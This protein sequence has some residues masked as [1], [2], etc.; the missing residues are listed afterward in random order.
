M[1]LALGQA[2]TP[3]RLAAAGA[4]AAGLALLSAPRAALLAAAAV[5]A[6]G[7]A[8]NVRLAAIDAAGERLQPGERVEGSA[9]LMSAPRAGPFGSS[10]EARM[11]SGP[12]LGA[13][14]LVR[15]P[16]DAR[17]AAGAGIG[18]E[19]VLAGIIRAPKP[20][21]EGEFD[22]AAYLRRR[23]VAGE[24]STERLRFTGRPRGRVAGAIDG[25][26][27]RAEE[28]IADGLSPGS[29]A[30]ARGMVL[31]QDEAIDPAVRDDFRVS[32]LAHVLTYQHQD[33]RRVCEPFGFRME[34][35][36]SVGG[37]IG[38]QFQSYTR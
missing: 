28:G 16:R 32:G 7:L 19:V 4:I 17:V 27:R 21:A 6:G 25:M 23:G 1:G 24:L 14:L 5:L 37:Q 3:T 2:P 22:L 38:L 8:G 34:S 12:A 35:F 26:R 10:A 11:A 18:S 9:H 15:F 33:R 30:H 31:G 36:H 13:R 29:Q 20:A